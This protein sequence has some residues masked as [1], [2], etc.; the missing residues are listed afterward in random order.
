MSFTDI[1]FGSDLLAPG[2]AKYFGG[3]DLAG[4]FGS[5][6]ATGGNMFGGMGGAM[7]LLGGIN[8]VMGGFQQAGLNRSA[9]NQFA[10]AN[11]MFDANFGRDMYAQNYDRFRSFQDPVMA[12]KI[13]VNDPS[14]RQRRT[15]DAL[16]ELAGRYGRFGAFVS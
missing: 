9:Q 7:G 2:A 3:G 15:L 8:S 16:P 5:G 14:Y 4:S 1:A 11:A 10:A 6:A 12:A 13:A